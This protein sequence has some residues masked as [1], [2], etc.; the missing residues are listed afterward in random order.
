M[1]LANKVYSEMDIELIDERIRELVQQRDAC[2][3]Q[4]R[5]AQNLRTIANML[6][7]NYRRLRR[8]ILQAMVDEF[9]IGEC[10]C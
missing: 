7:E 4:S 6:I 10:D 5:Q 9:F 3:C 2:N 1:G 8:Q